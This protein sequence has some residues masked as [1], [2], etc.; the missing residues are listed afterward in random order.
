MKQF[1]I[2]ALTLAFIP[3][4]SAVAQQE[5]AHNPLIVWQ[6]S[7]TITSLTGASCSQAGFTVGD[8]LHSIYRPNFDPAEPPTAVTLVYS[9]GALSFFRKSG[10]AQM[11]N[12]GAYTGAFIG[13]R[14]TQRPSG[15]KGPTTGNYNLTIAPNS[16]NANTTSNVD[17]DGTFTN[18]FGFTGCTLGFK[19]SYQRRP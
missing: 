5:A 4:A 6:G 12:A 15:S 18:F 1:I 10:N 14:A 2:A 3:A 9:R 13:G 7:A 16:I 17:I 11:R 8:L 19:A